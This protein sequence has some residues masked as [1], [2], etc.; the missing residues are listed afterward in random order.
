M[1]HCIRNKSIVAW[2]IVSETE[3]L[4]RKPVCC[5]MVH[6]IRSRSAV[7]ET[8]PL[9]QGP[10][11]SPF[12][13]GGGGGV[14]WGGVGDEEGRGFLCKNQVW[15]CVLVFLSLYHPSFFIFDD[16]TE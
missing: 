14:G 13:G 12:F 16:F 11:F 8:S 4:C 7:S 10:F 1:I 9:C 15:P 3:P 2:L 6:C 5:V